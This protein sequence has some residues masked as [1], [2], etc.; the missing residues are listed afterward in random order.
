MIY[1]ENINLTIERLYEVPSTNSYLAQLCKESKAKEF[2]T[3]ITDDQ[4]AG[5]GQR[6][7]T[8][9]SECGKNLTFS[10]V[11]YPTALEAKE[12]FYLS[13]AIAFATVDALENY[14]DGFS[15]KWPNDIYWKD[16]KIAGILIENELEGKFITQ[17]IV[18]IGLNVNQEVFHS[19]APNPVSLI[20]ILGVTINRQELL[21]R[22]L[23]G[24][25]AS[26]I[27]LEKDYK[28]AVHN[29]RQLYLRR[30]YRKEGFHPYRDKEGTFLAEFQD[31]EPSGHLVLKDEQGN[32]RRYAFKEVEFVLP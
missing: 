30:L 29:L 5:R 16:K 13:M 24:I 27:F 20:Q 12:Q 23:R 21:D 15:I 8:W 7:N 22:I 9:E 1:P 26:Y 3:V 17:S 11:L 14:T 18:G 28:M 31:V 25:M 19:S 4:T 2:H 6:G 32:L 10:T